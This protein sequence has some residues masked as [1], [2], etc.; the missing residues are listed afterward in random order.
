M[1]QDTRNIVN[2]FLKAI[3]LIWTSC[4]LLVLVQIGLTVLQ[5]ILPLGVLYTIKLLVDL[6]STQKGSLLGN[7]GES[8]ALSLLLLTGLFMLLE[9]GCRSI[10]VVV[11]SRLSDRVLDR[12]TIMLHEHSIAVD[13]SFYEQAVFFDTLQRAQQ[14]APYRPIGII[15]GLFSLLQSLVTLTA[16][17]GLLVSVHWSIALFL[18][19][20]LLP[21]FGVKMLF[22]RKNYSLQQKLTPARRYLYYFNTLL[23]TE[24]FAKEL[25]LFSLGSHFIDRYRKLRAEQRNENIAL[26]ER[27]AWYG[28]LSQMIALVSLLFSLGYL[29]FRSL[30][31]LLTIGSLVMIYQAMQ[32]A[33]SSVRSVLDAVASLYRDALFFGNFNEFL[34]HTPRIVSPAEPLPFPV[35][36]V[37]GITFS[38]VCFHY[39]DTER[40]VLTDFS[41]HIRPGEHVALVGENGSGKSTLVKLL[42]RLYEPDSGEILIDGI[43]YRKFDIQELRK[44]VS[45]VFQDY[46]RYYM[47]GRE[48]IRMGNIELPHDDGKIEQAARWSGAHEVLE[49]LE[50]GY[51]NVLG[52]LFDGGRELSLGEWQKIAIARA[53]LRDAPIM[54]LDE[55]SSSLDVEAEAELFGQFNELT[56]GKAALIIS[57]RLSTVR[58]ADRIVIL[59]DGKIAEEGSHDEL[60]FEDGIY[61]RLYRMQSGLYAVTV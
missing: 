47:S 26:V 4:P 27:E 56:L 5:G 40:N 15:T 59:S 61:A 28:F 10:A 35:P 22:S 33:Q 29:L 20:A 39:P 1:N 25:R 19:V 51:D 7:G 52:K 32:R 48:N 3:Q 58:M 43:D 37:K 54:I 50:S 44:Q 21:A 30:S 31:G 9:Q 18:F 36:I 2:A 45:V 53:F 17:A 13:L 38:K 34:R 46:V 16:L 42:C 60:M 6:F 23:T 8:S 57:H 14:E 55:P 12:V 11:S 49:G 24:P 41:L